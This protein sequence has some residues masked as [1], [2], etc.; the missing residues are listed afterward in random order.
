MTKAA[1]IALLLE[2][3]NEAEET[4]N[5]P[6]GTPGTGDR[7]PL[8]PPTWNRSMRELERCLKQLATHRPSQNWHLRE[9]YIRAQDVRIT[10]T[11]KNG[12]LRIPAHHT[13]IAGA[14]NTG[15]RKANIRCRRWNPAVRQH[16]V[17][18]ALDYL[19]HRYQ[20]EPYLH[21]DMLPDTVAA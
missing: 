21:P 16:K 13:L 18:L 9:R 15:E 6:G 10:V 20:G 5:A 3:Y 1:R 4:L 7:I 12:N 2:H 11:V 17:D 14:A 19:A 8:M